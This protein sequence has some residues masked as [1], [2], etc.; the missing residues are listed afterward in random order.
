MNSERVGR[1]GESGSGIVMQFFPMLFALVATLL[2]RFFVAG[3]LEAGGFMYTLFLPEGSVF[4]QLI[5]MSIMFLFFWSLAD[6]ALKTGSISRES[7][8]LTHEAVTKSP[9]RVGRLATDEALQELQGARKR[10]AGYVLGAVASVIEH[11]K[12]SNDIQRS[13]EH[14]RHQIDI[15]SETTTSGYTMVRVFIW[16]MPILG[17][18]GTVVGISLA[19]GDFSGFLSGDIDDIELVKQELANVANGLSFAF[20]TTLLGLVTS[21][22]AMLFATW[23]QH[24]G[25]LL[26]RGVEEMCLD[27]IASA[28]HPEAIGIAN[29]S[30]GGLVD[31]MQ[32]FADVVGEESERI[33][34]GFDNFNARFLEVGD[35]IV[36]TYS[37]LGTSLEA[38][39]TASADQMKASTSQLTNALTDASRAFYET[40]SALARDME[41]FAPDLG[42]TRKAIVEGLERVEGYNNQFEQVLRANTQQIVETQDQLGAKIVDSIGRIDQSSTHFEEALRATSMQLAASQDQLAMKLEEGIDRMDRSNVQFEEK[43]REQVHAMLGSQEQLAARLSDGLGQV[44]QSNQKFEEVLRANTQQVVASQEQLGVKMDGIRP[45]HEMIVKVTES[46]DN[47]K[48]AM[49][50]MKDVHETLV[51]VLEELRGPMEFKMVPAP[52]KPDGDGA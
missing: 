31:S 16:A 33:R 24:R 46:I 25:E 39:A 5:P 7:R 17:F 44:D 36:E 30:S 6:L 28:G 9:E 15:D 18:I 37:Q 12:M 26:T 2:F 48:S 27:I 4:Q 29:V 50:Q 3:F 20:N 10:G 41:S 42:G 14:F 1:V 34:E 13:H 8:L 23:V 21:L 40:T 47:A 32:G 49:Q 52:R 43:V 22:I 35:R 19:V 38:Q 11:L 51:P 45:T